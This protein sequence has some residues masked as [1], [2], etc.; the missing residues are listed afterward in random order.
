MEP[1]PD[2]ELTAIYARKSMKGDAQEI[3]VNRQKH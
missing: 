3:T 1:I 2:P